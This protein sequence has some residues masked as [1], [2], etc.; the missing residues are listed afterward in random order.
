MSIFAVVT[1]LSMD[2]SALLRT[3]SQGNDRAFDQIF[4]KYYPVL[5]AYSAR[6]V[7]LEEAEGI[8]Q[9]V[10]VTLWQ[11]CRNE[12]EGVRELSAWLY[13]TTYHRTLN[14]VTRQKI[15]ERA[16]QKFAERVAEAIGYAPDYAQ[17][18]EL[19]RH[20]DEAIAALPETFREAFM[21]HRFED[22]T[23]KEI[24][25]RLGVSPQTVA[26]RIGQALS[27]LRKDLKDYLP[28]LVWML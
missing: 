16:E 5:C 25:V 19:R 1:T 21:L 6:L 15:K 23:Y 7:P 11:T 10:M 17:L 26:Y 14:H 27:Q 8:V 24:A 3:F 2:D 4:R 20:V 28:M 22:L 18:E 12:E 9:E 13:S